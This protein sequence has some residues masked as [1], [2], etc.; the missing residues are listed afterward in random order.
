MHQLCSGCACT[1]LPVPSST[2]SAHPST[3]NTTAIC[4]LC[5]MTGGGAECTDF[6]KASLDAYNGSAPVTAEQLC[7]QYLPTLFD[8]RCS[9]RLGVG[10]CGR[11]F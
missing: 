1:A 3:I 6:L 10:L 5:K 11:C 2:P 4:R 7:Y 9:T 8:S